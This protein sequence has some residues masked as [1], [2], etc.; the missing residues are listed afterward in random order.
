MDPGAPIVADSHLS[1]AWS[2]RALTIPGLVVLFLLDLALLPLVLVVALVVDLARGRQLAATRF[3]LALAI[4]LG[5][6]VVGL[7]IVLRGWLGGRA[8][9][10]ARERELDVRGELW[11][12]ETM[13]KAAAWL[14]G[15]RVVVE[16]DEVFA[17]GGPIVFL[18]RHASLADILL[19]VVFV[20]ARHGFVPRWVA[21]RELLWDPAIDLFG[22]RVGFA[23][24]RRDHRQHDADVH[25]VASLAEA[26]GPRD[27]LVVF[28][29]GTRFTEPKRARALAALAASDPATAARFA[30][31]RHVLP[32]HAGGTF[33]ALDR[34]RDADVVFCAH[35][36][37]EGVRQLRDLAEGSLV[38]RTLRLRYWRV[39]AREVPTEHA[40]RVA[41]LAGWWERMDAWIGEHVEAPRPARTRSRRKVLAT[42]AAFA[43]VLAS[44]TKGGAGEPEKDPSMV[45]TLPPPTTGPVLLDDALRRRRS[46]RAFSKEPLS[47]AH[48]G[49]L[50]WSAQ[51]VT[52]PSGLR[53]APSAG[54]LYPLEIHVVLP[55]GARSG[56]RSSRPGTPPRTSCSRRLR[57]GS[58]QSRSAPS[59]TQR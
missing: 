5:M 40:A 3:H 33:A 46:A 51:G 19:P 22:H 54:A 15:M 47:R 10:P 29:E 8:A 25:A 39:P 50:C 2:R 32:P 7:L 4:V 34:A 55:E 53:T 18:A 30:R 17:T 44:D 41:W 14:Y 58:R 1:T 20:A 52:D 49:Q 56:T 24:V 21:K 45:I 31:L 12:A 6:H 48:L 59:T 42:L 9:G 23:F 26:L 27:L 28:P 16:G 57:S 11:W 35:T 13:W 43:L 38:G 37:L 36:G